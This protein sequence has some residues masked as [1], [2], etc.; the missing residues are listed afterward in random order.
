LLT[1]RI[2]RNNRTLVERA[3]EVLADNS[4]SLDGIII[5]SLSSL[6]SGYGY[7]S[8]N[9]YSKNAYGYVDSYR[10][11]YAVRTEAPTP[12]NGTFV[13]PASEPAKPKSVGLDLV[14]SE[15]SNS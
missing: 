1:I 13:S 15:A 5:N 12:A 3:C 2:E 11:Q 14:E 10:S 4:T 7:S 6:G 8:Y 9:Y